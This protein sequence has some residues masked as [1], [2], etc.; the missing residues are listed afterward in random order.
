M[1]GGDRR[2]SQN[3][4]SHPDTTPLPS[5]REVNSVST[6]SGLLFI[7]F[8]VLQPAEAK[9]SLPQLK[10]PS[11]LCIVMLNAPSI[12]IQISLC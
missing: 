6:F 7:I 11:L 12:T 4:L 5:D 3:L 9:C 1:G 8:L 2:G 10:F